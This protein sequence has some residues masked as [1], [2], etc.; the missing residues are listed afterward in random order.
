MAV[1]GVVVGSGCEGREGGGE[2]RRAVVCDDAVIVQ[3]I[4][5]EEC[6]GELAGNRTGLKP[7]ARPTV[8]NAKDRPNCKTLSDGGKW[9]CQV[10]I[11]AAGRGSRSDAS[12]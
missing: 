11:R 5:G 2:G 7:E 10:T 8:C 12:N 1:R 4:S 9:R 6:G 3:I